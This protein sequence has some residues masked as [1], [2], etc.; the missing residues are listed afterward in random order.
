M[1]EKYTNDKI[2]YIFEQVLELLLIQI[3]SL[4]E[5]Y[6]ETHLDEFEINYRNDFKE[7]INNRLKERQLDVKIAEFLLLDQD[8]YGLDT[9]ENNI[10]FIISDIFRE[11]AIDLSTESMVIKDQWKKEQIERFT[12]EV[13]KLSKVI[14]KYKQEMISLYDDLEMRKEQIERE[15]EKN[16]NFKIEIENITKK[17]D[18][19]EKS[20]EKN[21]EKSN[22]KIS[23]Y[24][25]KLKQSESQNLKLN[26]E[27]EK[28]EI[29]KSKLTN[30]AKK[31]NEDKEILNNKVNELESFIKVIQKEVKKQNNE[32]INEINKL[33]KENEYLKKDVDA[34]KSLNEDK[35]NKLREVISEKEKLEVS[36]KTIQKEAKKKQNDDNI[37][38]ISK[39]KKEKE[40]L[41]NGVDVLKNQNIEKEKELR[42]VINEKQKIDI[43]NKELS[44]MLSEKDKQ[45]IKLQQKI[46]ELS[47]IPT[48]PK[49]QI[50]EIKEEYNKIYNELFTKLKEIVAID[51]NKTIG[52]QRIMPIASNINKAARTIKGIND[53][54]IFKSSLEK[55]NIELYQLDDLFTKNGNESGLTQF[56]QEFNKLKDKI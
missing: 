8:P 44:N 17:L 31:L 12:N 35:E 37:N 21:I 5:E 54:L 27:K 3:R 6:N 38:E 43:E 4:Y 48:P 36:I 28:L 30:N 2:S 11:I 42:K 32:N 41:K 55:L 1:G 33:K 15:K 34:L 10:K 20:L 26:K 22:E 25:N 52:G 56:I 24:E 50:D 18:L 9:T 16:N 13:E 46:K 7:L 39:L 49:P 19:T 29:E 14:E 40:H 47:I 51:S 53:M 23:K 45:I